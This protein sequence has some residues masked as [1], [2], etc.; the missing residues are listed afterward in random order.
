MRA[1]LRMREHTRELRLP[2]ARASARRDQERAQACRRGGGDLPALRGAR[3][4]SPSKLG[5]GR[6]E[7]RQA[8]GFFFAPYALITGS[9]SR[10][11]PVMPLQALQSITHGV[12]RGADGIERSAVADLGR[13][14]VRVA[15]AAESGLCAHK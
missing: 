10:D 5:V 2:R 9:G 11:R 3:Y 8:R 4:L 13:A 1:R 14:L 15:R 7:P 12:Q 6:T